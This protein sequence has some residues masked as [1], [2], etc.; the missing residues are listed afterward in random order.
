MGIFLRTFTLQNSGVEI[1]FY[2][3]VE[4]KY[5][6]RTHSATVSITAITSIFIIVLLEPQKL[7]Q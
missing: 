3:F 1:H 2:L 4:V 5:V 6:E 7:G